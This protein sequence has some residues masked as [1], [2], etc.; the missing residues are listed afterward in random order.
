M[1][2]FYLAAV[3]FAILALIDGSIIQ[4]GIGLFFAFAGMLT[5]KFE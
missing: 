3:I 2:I 4:L 5:E 1:N